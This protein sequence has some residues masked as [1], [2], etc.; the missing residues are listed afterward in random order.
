MTICDIRE[1][2]N[3]RLGPRQ[4]SWSQCRIFEQAQSCL[5]A[6]VIISGEPFPCTPSQLIYQV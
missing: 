1:G 3:G 6:N 4:V 2:R 5:I